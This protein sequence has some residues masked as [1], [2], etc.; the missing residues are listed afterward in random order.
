MPRVVVGSVALDSVE[1]PT[2]TREDVLGG[3]A[4]YFAY[5]ASFFTPVRLLSVVGE[6]WPAEHTRLLE[7]RSI[8]VSGLQVVPGMAT[9]RWRGK[10]LTDMNQRETLDLKLNVLS[11]FEPVLPEA[12]RR[13]RYLFLANGSPVPSRTPCGPVR[14]LVSPRCEPIATRS[15]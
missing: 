7:E 3:S 8:D 1:T 13:C 6:D 5:A 9:F 15:R 2:E 14:M 12:Y 11:H 4:A 10:Y